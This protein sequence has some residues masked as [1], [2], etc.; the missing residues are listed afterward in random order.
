MPEATRPAFIT[1]AR[2]GIEKKVGQRGPVPVF[3]S[4]ACRA[5]TANDRRID[6]ECAH[7]G[8][9]ASVR[10]GT[11]YCS[12]S[13]RNAGNYQ[14]AREDGRYDAELARR[15]ELTARR[16]VANAKPCPYCGEPMFHSRRVQCGA[17]PCRLQHAA[18]WMR[19]WQRAYR[20]KH[21]AWYRAVNYA[22][23]QRAYDRRR[24]RQRSHWRQLY[25]ELAATYDARRRALVQQARTE[26]VFAPLDVH[27]RDNWTCQLCWLPIDPEVAWPDPMSPSIDH[28]IPL[29]RG[30][31][32]ALSNVQSAHL[33]CNSS[34]GD[35]DMVEVFFK[36]AS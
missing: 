30:G 7:C 32:H 6:I 26:D 10:V 31:A 17:E 34:K 20:D 33:R 19:Q 27:A 2:C 28:V 14:A 25:P 16:R 8:Q 24:R 35:K 18:N 22:E 9:P 11:R 12:A 36:L 13:C 3:C 29:S 1:C 5:G 15:R 23:Q 4:G 21:G